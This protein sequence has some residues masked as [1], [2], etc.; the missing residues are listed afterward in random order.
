MPITNSTYQ[1]DPP[2]AL[3]R[4]QVVERH[5]DHLGR[6]H[7][8]T[9]TCEAEWSPENIM[10]LRAIKLGADVDRAEAEAIAANGGTA[11]KTWTQ[12]EFWK[13][14]TPAEYATCK[15]LAATDPVANYFLTLLKATPVIFAN[16]PSLLPGLKYFEA[17]GS[18]AV[19]RAAEVVNG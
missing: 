13:L 2:D 9:Y 17:A 6:E 18:L 1:A 8:V 3:G 11:I 12:V 10:Q 4:F 5:T 14:F 19:G 7:L 15:T 16:D